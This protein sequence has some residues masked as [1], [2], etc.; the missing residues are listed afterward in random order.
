VRV[1]GADVLQEDD[2]GDS[3]INT[4]FWRNGVTQKRLI[5]FELLDNITIILFTS[6]HN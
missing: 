2:L 5:K 1:H 4:T 6:L 3:V